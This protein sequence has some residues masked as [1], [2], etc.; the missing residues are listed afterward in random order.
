M[1]EAIYTYLLPLPMRIKGYTVLMDD[2]YTII[3]NSN[4]CP[5]ARMRAYR[6][7]IRHIRN[8]DLR[9]Q[10]TADHI[11]SIAHKGKE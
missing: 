1:T 6:H 11:E 10:R 5:D 4:L 2:V 9:S 8:E 3:I 7:E